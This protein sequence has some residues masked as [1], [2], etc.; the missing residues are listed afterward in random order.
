MDHE[1]IDYA[2]YE[3]VEAIEENNLTIIKGTTSSPKDAPNIEG[4]DE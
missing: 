1:L 3:Y 2:Y 4:D